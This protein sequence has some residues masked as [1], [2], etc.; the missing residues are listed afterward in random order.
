MLRFL[1]AE[2]PNTAVEAHFVRRGQFCWAVR[3][4]RACCL[5]RRPLRTVSATSARRRTDR[6]LAA[7]VA[8]RAAISAARRSLIG[9]VVA[10]SEP[11]FTET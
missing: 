9:H 1:W 4:G 8:S 7:E 11:G 6:V 10:V 3:S 2:R 5:R